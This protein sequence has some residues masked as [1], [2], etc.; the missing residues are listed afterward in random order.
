ME[1][2]GANPIEMAMCPD[3]NKQTEVPKYP[4]EI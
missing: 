2:D 1:M 4:P 3:W